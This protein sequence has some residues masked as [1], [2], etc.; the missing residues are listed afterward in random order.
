[1]RIYKSANAFML[2]F[3]HLYIT[4]V[5]EITTMFMYAK[6]ILKNICLHICGCV[7]TG[8]RGNVTFKIGSLKALNHFWT[9]LFINYSYNQ[10]YSSILN[11]FNKYTFCLPVSSQSVTTDFNLPFATT[12]CG[13]SVNMKNVFL[14]NLIC[15]L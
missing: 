11:Y 4:E 1:M 8:E 14:C 15:I 3:N 9:W 2:L 6:C 10:Q 12:N 7:Y 5:V 13:I